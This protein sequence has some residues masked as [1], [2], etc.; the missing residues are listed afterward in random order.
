MREETVKMW[1]K[2]KCICL[3]S[4]RHFLSAAEGNLPSNRGQITIMANHWIEEAR[5]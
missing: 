3:G 5:Y 2:R 4:F 1:R